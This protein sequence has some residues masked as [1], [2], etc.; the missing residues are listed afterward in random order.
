M[1]V[2]V[3]KTVKVPIIS[4]HPNIKM[5]ISIVHQSV[6]WS[7]T[8]S[9]SQSVGEL[10][11]QLVSQSAGYSVNPIVSQLITSPVHPLVMIS[12]SASHSRSK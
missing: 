12:H 5:Y 3:D 2:P 7:V 11:S 4:V 1:A 10:F 6:S 9:V 8:K